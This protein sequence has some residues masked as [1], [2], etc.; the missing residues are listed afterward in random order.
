MICNNCGFEPKV[1]FGIPALISNEEL[2]IHSHN[3][4][5]LPVN[6]RRNKTPH[7]KRNLNFLQRLFCQE[8]IHFFNVLLFSC[9]FGLKKMLKQRYD[10][11]VEKALYYGWKNYFNLI[12]KAGEILQFNKMKKYIMEPSLEIGCG[13]SQTTNMIFRDSLE[14]ITFGCEYFMNNFLNV[15]GR[16]SEEM[17]KVIK[18]YVGGSIKSLPFRTGIFKSVIMVH[19]LDHIVQIDQCFKEINRV[20]KE[21]GCLIMTAYSKNTF[22]HLPGAKSRKIFSAEWSKRYKERRITMDNPRGSLLRSDFEYDATGQNMFSIEE[23][24]EIAKTHGFEVVDYAFFG[25]YF[26]YFM[27]IEY[28]GYCNS[29]LFNQFIYAAISEIIEREKVNPL[30]EKESTNIILVFKKRC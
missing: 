15:Q 17:Y 7:K 8:T 1:R 23:W 16:L 9:K 24:K 11:R 10:K 21:E 13:G 6:E 12:L 2:G 26:S 4:L 28:R 5:N 22:E 20:L 14:S 27:D 3:F 30:S 18:D 25:N 19:I 29:L